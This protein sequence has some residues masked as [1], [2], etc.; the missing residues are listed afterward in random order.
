MADLSE[1][2]AFPFV[3]EGGLV[4]NQSTFIMKPGQALELENFE[5]DIEG[6]YRRISG[7]SKY[8]SGIVPITSDSSEEILMVATFAS[9]V[10]AARG[11]SIYQ[12]TPGGSSWTSI[13][14]S[15]TS[16]GKYSFER[17]NFDG[18]NKLI[19]VDG[20][21]DPTVFNTSFTTT[22]AFLAT[23]TSPAMPISTFGIYAALTIVSNYIFVIVRHMYM[24]FKLL[25]N[26]LSST[27]EPYTRNK[28]ID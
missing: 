15:R 13:D 21:N 23:A 27:T 24:I 7:F 26:L 18:N 11:T 25:D 5:P 12:A 8:V 19:V 6:G 20:A 14:S 22:V 10:V 16:A 28:A 2:A 4:L 17:F 9:K 3:C 1:T